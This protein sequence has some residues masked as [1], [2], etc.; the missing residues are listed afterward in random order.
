MN[1]SGVPEIVIMDH[2]LV[3]SRVFLLAVVRVRWLVLILFLLC[4]SC[5]CHLLLLELQLLL[6]EHLLEVESW[7]LDGALVLGIVATARFGVLEIKPV[8]KLFDC[9][10]LRVLPHGILSR[11]KHI[12]VDGRRLAGSAQ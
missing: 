10:K 8:G 7:H 9:S 2:Y 1:V 4:Y 5:S 6:L 3:V 12:A 11:S